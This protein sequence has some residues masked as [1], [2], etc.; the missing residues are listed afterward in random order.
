MPSIHLTTHGQFARSMRSQ[1]CPWAS[2]QCVVVDEAHEVLQNPAGNGYAQFM[3]VQQGAQLRPSVAEEESDRVCMFATATPLGNKPQ[4]L[5]TL[6][7]AANPRIFFD[8]EVMLREMWPSHLRTEVCCNQLMHR[9]EVAHE[10]VECL[11]PGPNN[12]R[13]KFRCALGDGCRV[14]GR[15]QYVCL[16]CLSL[17]HI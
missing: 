1:S 9:S 6:F 14:H 11:C 17:I 15:E 16:R 5:L 4:D 12:R 8:A 7:E 2:A 13:H 10:E 3:K